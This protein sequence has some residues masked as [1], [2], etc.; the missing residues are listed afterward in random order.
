M[1]ERIRKKEVNID[2]SSGKTENYA[3]QVIDGVEVVDVKAVPKEKPVLNKFGIPE[4]RERRTWD[5]I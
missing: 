1:I 3:S 4:P 2:P 5:R